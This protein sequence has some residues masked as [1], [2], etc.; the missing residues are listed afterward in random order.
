[1]LPWQGVPMLVPT[2]DGRWRLPDGHPRIP[3]SFSVRAKKGA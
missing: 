3:V 2:P 1:V